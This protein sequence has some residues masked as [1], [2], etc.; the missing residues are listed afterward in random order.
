M[1]DVRKCNEPGLKKVKDYEINCTVANDLKQSDLSN[2]KSNGGGGGVNWNK[3]IND[4]KFA[5]VNFR[6]CVK[7]RVPE[8]KS[9]LTKRRRLEVIIRHG[10]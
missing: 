6:H 10:S 1:T 2:M 8:K 4:G 3:N 5:K 9:V 7:K